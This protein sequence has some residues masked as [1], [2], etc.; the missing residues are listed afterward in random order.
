M[1]IDAFRQRALAEGLGAHRQALA[2]GV[3]AYRRA[4]AAQMRGFV[5]GAPAL[6]AGAR[7][8]TAGAGAALAVLCW[9]SLCCSWLRLPTLRARRA[10]WT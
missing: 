1:N 10:G 2:A 9:R 7:V 5:A 4:C 8:F 3:N 6:A